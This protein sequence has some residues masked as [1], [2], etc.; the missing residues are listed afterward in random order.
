MDYFAQSFVMQTL[1]SIQN[2]ETDALM[3]TESYK[4]KNHDPNFTELFYL[5]KLLYQVI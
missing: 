3:T 1:Y 2:L 4:K 5:S